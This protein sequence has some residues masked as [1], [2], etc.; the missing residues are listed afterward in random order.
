MS[1][2]V[3]LGN[4][5]TRRPTLH[6][7]ADA[8]GSPL[9][10]TTASGVPGTTYTYEPFGRTAVDGPALNPF[11]Y[12][13]REHDGTGLY[14]YRARYYDAIRARF[15]SKDPIGL[16][17][18][19]NDYSYVAGD[20][21]SN[22]DPAGLWF[23]IDDLVFAG[24]GAVVGALGRGVGDLLTRK[25]SGWEDYAGAAFGGAVAGETLLYTA[26]PFLAGA[27]GGL[28]GNLAGQALKNL[29]GR[30]CGLDVGSAGF[31]M[32]FGVLTGLIP[33]RPGI[34]GI[35]AGRGS[36]VQVFRQVMTKAAD[37]SIGNI[38]PATALRM[39]RGAFYEYAI[40]QGA[41]AGAV[42]STVYGSLFP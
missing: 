6:Y 32:A 4:V 20:P 24:G 9:A 33:G 5:P 29:S 1:C 22:T 31:D 25:L 14:Y 34:T 26:N 41:A 38:R 17:G 18:G 7:V 11:Q 23:G 36:D 2:L 13:G 12:T 39:G 16:A 42:G 19:I 30:Q 3:I 28:A 8:L 37:G 21:I 35:N 15:V 10:L 27:A 40:G